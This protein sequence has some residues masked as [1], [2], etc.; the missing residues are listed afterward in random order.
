MATA[1]RKRAP[2]AT[3][4]PPPASTADIVSAMVTLNAQQDD[5]GIT[6]V[7]VGGVCAAIGAILLALIF[8]VGSSV[9]SL[10]TNV[11][12]M[13]ANVD[14]L[15]KSIS[16]LQT[17]QGTASQQLADGKATD[18]RQDARADAIDADINRMKE[19]VRILEGQKPLEL[20]RRYAD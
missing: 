16:D 12:K 10:S 2:K 11:T 20:N 18:A 7:I 17:T 6:K 13:S 15:Q 9:N 14:Q 19:R 3:P 8:W 5:R 1:P 4:A